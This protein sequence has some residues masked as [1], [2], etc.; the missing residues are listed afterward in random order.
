MTL[1]TTVIFLYQKLHPEDGW[2][3]WPKHVGENIIN[4]Y[5]P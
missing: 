3:N 5:M 2:I 1:L 4:K